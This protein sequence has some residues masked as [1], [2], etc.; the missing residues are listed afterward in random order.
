MIK[1]KE[2]NWTFRNCLIVGLLIGVCITVVITTEYF[3]G[4]AH[5]KFVAY[6]ELKESAMM[7]E[8]LAPRTLLTYLININKL[9]DSKPIIPFPA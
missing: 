7:I 2:S 4:Q 6:V 3:F 9:I 5:N 8:N 1:G